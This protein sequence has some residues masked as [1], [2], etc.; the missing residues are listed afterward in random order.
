MRYVVLKCFLKTI[1]RIQKFKRELR[2]Q[3]EIM[4]RKIEYI[5]YG[6]HIQPSNLFGM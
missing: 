4:T 5:S 3:I 2:F 1:M 6:V